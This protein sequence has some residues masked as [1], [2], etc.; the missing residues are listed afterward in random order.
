QAAPYVELAGTAALSKIEVSGTLGSLRA[1]GELAV[2]PLKL[3]GKTFARLDGGFT[4]DGERIHLANVTLAAG[5]G[6]VRIPEA[7]YQPAG[8]EKASPGERAEATGLFKGIPVEL[9]LAVARDSPFLGT[10]DGASLLD[11]L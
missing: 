11:T 9:L 3:N 5:T 10:P 1:S 2:A 4:W 6:G 8:D 7:S